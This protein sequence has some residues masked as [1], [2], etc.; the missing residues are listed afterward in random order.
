[1]LL[2]SR[3]AG[4]P[5]CGALVVPLL[6]CDGRDTIQGRWAGSVKDLRPRFTHTDI[7]AGQ[8]RLDDRH[9]SL[10]CRRWER[11]REGVHRRRVASTG[12]GPAAWWSLVI[13]STCQVCATRLLPIHPATPA[14]RRHGRGHSTRPGASRSRRG[15]STPSG[16]AIPPV[17][18]GGGCTTRG[19][20]VLCLVLGLVRMCVVMRWRGWWL[21]SRPRRWVGFWGT[22]V[23]R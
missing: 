9:A 3:R 14:H 13:D 16:T 7:H 4:T 19:R 2:S 20:G 6:C 18:S 23:G 12:P 15:H 8:R 11:S 5:R 21:V 1:M 22:G 17:G 10:G